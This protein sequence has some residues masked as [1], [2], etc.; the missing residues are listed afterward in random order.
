MTP[1]EREELQRSIANGV[2][3]GN[4]QARN[5]YD[6]GDPDKVEPWFIVCLVIVALAL[7]IGNMYR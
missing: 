4:F 1:Q 3:R 5:G 7:T 6:P 2:Y